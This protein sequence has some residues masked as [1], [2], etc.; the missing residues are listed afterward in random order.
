MFKKTLMTVGVACASMGAVAALEI[1]QGNIC[2]GGLWKG[3]Y[4]GGTYTEHF[5]DC[6]GASEAW[7]NEELYIPVLGTGTITPIILHGN[8]TAAD[9]GTVKILTDQQMIDRFTP[10]GVSS[11]KWDGDGSYYEY[12]TKSADWAWPSHLWGKSNKQKA[13]RRWIQIPVKKSSNWSGH[14]VFNVALKG[15]SEVTD[16]P[17]RIVPAWEDYDAPGQLPL[18]FAQYMRRLS[19]GGSGVSYGYDTYYIGCWNQEAESWLGGMVLSAEISNYT[20]TKNIYGNNVFTIKIP[21]AGTLVAVSELDDFDSLS[22]YKAAMKVTG[23][24][25]SKQTYKTYDYDSLKAEDILRFGMSER[26]IVHRI[27]ASKATTLTFAEKGGC[28]WEGMLRFYPSAKRSVH[29]NAIYG[30]DLWG[31]GPSGYV[32]GTGNYKEGEMV[33]LKAVTAS[34]Q[35]F[36]GWDWCYGAC[37]ANWESIRES[38]ALSF[39]V[40]SEM[41]GAEA[42][43]KQIYVMPLWEY[44]TDVIAIPM[45]FHAGSVAGGGPKLIG[46]TVMLTP[47]PA[48]GYHFTGWEDDPS[49]PASAREIQV[50][51]GYCRYQANFAINTYSIEFHANGG[52]GT[53]APLEEI[54][55]STAVT[56]PKNTFRRDNCVFKGWATT[57]T[58]AVK[59]ANGASV[60]KL[61]A[62]HE[63]AVTLYAVW[64]P[65]SAMTLYV[66]Q[67]V[68]YKFPTLAKYKASTLPKGLKWSASSSYGRLTGTLAKAQTVTVTFTK[69]SSKVK[70]K[71]SVKK[72]AVVTNVIPKLDGGTPNADI[73]L[74]IMSYAGAPQSI[75]VEGLP[76]GLSFVDGRIVGPILFAGTKNVTITILSAVGT[77]ISKTIKLTANVPTVCLGE[78]E[79]AFSSSVIPSPEGY[80]FDE[81]RS[82]GNFAP[83]GLLEVKADGTVTFKTL[84]GT[85][86]GELAF[87]EL[88][89]EPFVQMEGTYMGHDLRAT[90]WCDE[91]DSWSVE[92]DYP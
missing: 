9:F 36:L 28:E 21:E 87:D 62:T 73:D 23:S 34:G 80:C 66:N 83:N 33:T 61:T 6:Y 50:D 41:V 60:S 91:E 10:K 43:E 17:L 18:T 20:K 56:L 32:T 37:P 13:D 31:N 38:P 40:T 15:T 78:H 11:S 88:T 85:L 65:A 24:G 55:Y 82:I 12:E 63:G 3:N 8:T 30:D 49:L 75:D 69:G 71:I 53:M 79:F 67:K 89:M 54:G 19:V 44:Q 51:G 45:P 14:K 81:E 35:K 76:Q 77:T 84:R 7:G 39:E 46:D 1:D 57:A 48:T 2:D 25:I 64:A 70:V 27:K 22:E 92:I 42:E 5:L 74:G 72:D 29:V 58:G 86:A 90:F 59:Y 26:L 47:K 4:S 68:D 16:S 52:S